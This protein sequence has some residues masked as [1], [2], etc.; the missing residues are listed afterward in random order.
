MGICTSTPKVQPTSELEHFKNKAEQAEQRIQQMNHE[1]FLKEN[2]TNFK[3][4]TKRQTL[5]SIYIKPNHSTTDG[6]KDSSNRTVRLHSLQH[7]DSYGDKSELS[8]EDIKALAVSDDLDIVLNAPGHWD[9]F[10]SHTQRNADAREIGTRL[11]TSFEKDYEMTSWIDVKM[12][13]RN[14]GAMKEGV[15]NSKCLIAILTDACV[16]N[17]KPK[18]PPETN[19]YF[20]RNYCVQEL[21]WAI[22]HFIQI[23]PVIRA[24]DKQ[25]IGNIISQ[26]PPDLKFLAD[27]D[28][29]HLD[30]S[31]NEYFDL[32]VRKIQRVIET[33]RDIFFTEEM[34]L[35]YKD[36]RKL[37]KESNQDRDSDEDSD[38]NSKKHSEFLIFHK[39]TVEELEKQLE[40]E[41]KKTN[42]EK[43]RRIELNKKNFET[44]KNELSEQMISIQ[45]KSMGILHIQDSSSETKKPTR[46]RRKSSYK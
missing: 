45:R 9:I 46:L 44:K 2:D 11:E 28:F 29:I 32:G 10:I 16:N 40:D 8:I 4:D 30:R 24:E 25:N 12:D 17:N 31:D 41:K 38:P 42:I 21:R 14:V 27:I 19:A 5:A 39:N 15:I 3:N 33:D 13:C 20:R 35:K 1:K 26:A 22:E 37:L 7:R 23:Q 43:A 36:S 34:I 18:D 6:D